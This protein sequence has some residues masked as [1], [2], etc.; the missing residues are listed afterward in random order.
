MKSNPIHCASEQR[1]V[2]ISEVVRLT[3]L[4]RSYVYSLAAEGR[5]P[6]SIPL[7]PGGKSRAWVLSEVHDWL[8]QRIAERALED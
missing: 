7:V 8:S 6:K 4:S 1:L 2:R 5:F 3:G